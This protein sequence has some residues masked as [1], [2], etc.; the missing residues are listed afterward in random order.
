MADDDLTISPL[1]GVQEKAGKNQTVM[2]NSV[3]A[4]FAGDDTDNHDMRIDAR[5]KG[6]MTICLANES[7]KLATVTV[8]GMHSLSAD[9]DSYGSV[10]LGQDAGDSQFTVAAA[11]T[12]YECYNDPFPFFLIRVTLASGGDG[13][14]VTIYTDLQQQ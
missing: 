4:S 12:G 2:P 8:Y 5:G 13:E 6:R 11:T 1:S 14:D 7:D 3:Y 10:E 9:H